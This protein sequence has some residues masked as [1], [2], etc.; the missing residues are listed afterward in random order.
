MAMVWNKRSKNNQTM[1]VFSLFTAPENMCLT[2]T[3]SLKADGILEKNPPANAG[4]GKVETGYP[5]IAT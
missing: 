5:R 1:A 4:F 2:K 3:L